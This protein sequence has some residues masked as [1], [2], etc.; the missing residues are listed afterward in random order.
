V[1]ADRPPEPLKRGFELSADEHR[2]VLLAL[3]QYHEC[4]A[5]D[6][7]AEMIQR[8]ASRLPEPPDVIGR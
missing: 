3:S 7:E 8:V 2:V 5:T 1:A 4:Y 6:A